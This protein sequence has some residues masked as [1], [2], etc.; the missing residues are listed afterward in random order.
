MGPLQDLVRLAVAGLV[1]VPGQ[2]VTVASAVSADLLRPGLDDPPPHLPIPFSGMRRGSLSPDRLTAPAKWIC[3]CALRPIPDLPSAPSPSG[4]GTGASSTSTIPC[5][6]NAGPDRPSPAQL[7]KKKPGRPVG[8][9]EGCAWS[10]SAGIPLECVATTCVAR[11]LAFSGRWVRCIAMPR[12]AHSRRHRPPCASGLRSRRRQSRRIRCPGGTSPVG[13][14]RHP[15]HGK[16]LELL[17]R[18]RATMFE[19]AWHGVD[20]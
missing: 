13:G 4:N 19:P 14:R 2:G 3:A 11:N 18:H 1:R 20:A 6:T 10:R 9:D 16:R 5:G 7:P 8:P 12:F 15:R 17:E